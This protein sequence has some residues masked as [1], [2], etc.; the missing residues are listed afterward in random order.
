MSFCVSGV[1]ARIYQEMN[2]QAQFI[3]IFISFHQFLSQWCS[4]IN[5]EVGCGKN[6][7]R[8]LNPLYLFP[9]QLFLHQTEVQ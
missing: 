2:N 3:Q 7:K 1:V 5:L 9:R 6:A 8:F 4:H